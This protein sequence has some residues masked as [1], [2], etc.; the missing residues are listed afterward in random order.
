MF[1]TH[2]LACPCG[3]MNRGHLLENCTT[4]PF[5]TDRVSLGSPAICHLRILTGSDSV[6]MRVAEVL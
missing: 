5:S 6:E 1:L 3:S 2:L 4:T